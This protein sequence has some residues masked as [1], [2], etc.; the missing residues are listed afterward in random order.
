MKMLYALSQG[1]GGDFQSQIA[2]IVGRNNKILDKA[3]QEADENRQ[4]SMYVDFLLP[5]LSAGA[6]VMMD[7]VLYIMMYLPQMSMG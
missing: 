3:E 5:Q 7:M 2:E 4:A 6:L 1:A